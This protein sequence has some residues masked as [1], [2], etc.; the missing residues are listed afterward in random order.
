MCRLSVDEG[1]VNISSSESLSSARYCMAISFSRQNSAKKAW[2]T[3]SRTVLV[4]SNLPTVFNH[5]GLLGFPTQ[6]LP[7]IG[8]RY[9]FQCRVRERDPDGKGIVAALNA[10]D[11]GGRIEKRLDK[12]D[13]WAT[14]LDDNKQKSGLCVRLPLLRRGR[15]RRRP[16]A[17]PM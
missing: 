13:R 4:S 7:A 5:C 12:N 11:Y 16:R 15:R 17:K 3:C 10:T 8:C 1:E 14:R 2:T 9:S 6:N